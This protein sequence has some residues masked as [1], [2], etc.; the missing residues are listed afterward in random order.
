MSKKDH[1]GVI[2]VNKEEIIPMKKTKL[3]CSLDWQKAVKNKKAESE[4]EQFVF[5][6]KPAIDNLDAQGE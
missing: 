1:E 4:R 5:A 3:T 6:L 2:L